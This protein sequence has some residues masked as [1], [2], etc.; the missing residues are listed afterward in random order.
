MSSQMSRFI[1]REDLSFVR[2][3]LYAS[4]RGVINHMMNSTSVLVEA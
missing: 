1:D 4:D 3:Q 2:M